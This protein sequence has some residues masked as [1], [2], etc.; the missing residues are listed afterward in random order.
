MVGDAV[1][2]HVAAAPLDRHGRARLVFGRDAHA[3][4]GGRAA[5]HRAR[6][7]PERRIPDPA[8]HHQGLHHARGHAV[9]GA[10]LIT[11]DA[12][13]VL[14]PGN[15]EYEISTIGE[16][17]HTLGAMFLLNHRNPP[18]Q[19]VPPWGPVARNVL[20]QGA[21]V[22]FDKLVWPF[23][24]TLPVV[25]GDELY[26]LANNH[27]WRTD[28]AFRQWNWNAAP[29]LQPPYG[30]RGPAGTRM[31][32]LHTGHVLHAAE[33]RLPSATQRRHGQRRASRCPSD[34]AIYVYLPDGFSYDKWLTG[35]RRRPEL[36]RPPAPC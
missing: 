16:K 3:P 32:Q 5:Q 12:T 19:G 20:A 14:W 36:R 27:M 7:G 24:M 9:S 13:H 35:L 4:L 1:N 8:P 28:F 11:I 10:Q 25:A 22:D 15:T 34:S 30:G 31:D 2:I 6:R 26:E 17:S 21:L 23:A 29:Y 33:L 18:S